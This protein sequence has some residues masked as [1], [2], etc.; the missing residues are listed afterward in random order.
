MEG[1][2]RKIH[3]GEILHSVAKREKKTIKTIANEAGFEKSTFYSH[4]KKE[5]LSLD[6]LF[7]YGKAIP[8]DF[9]IEIPEM[10][11][12]SEKYRIKKNQIIKPTYEV[13]LQEKEDWKDKFYVLLEEYT[14]LLKD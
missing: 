4:V 14:K 13:L 1:K 7:R 9:E 8:H 12:F 5:D 3:R 2:I 11:E 10:V 6:I